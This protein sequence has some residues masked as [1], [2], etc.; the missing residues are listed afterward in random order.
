MSK[1]VFIKIIT[2]I[3]VCSMVL[4]TTAYAYGNL[5]VSS[6]KYLKPG[7]TAR[8]DKVTVNKGKTLKLHENF[9]LEVYDSITVKANGKI[10]GGGICLRSKSVSSS[11]INFYENIGG[12]YYLISGG[13][14]II[15][16]N[17]SE[18]D[19]SPNLWYDKAVGGY[20]FSNICNGGST[21]GVDTNIG[22]LNENHPDY[23]AQ[24]EEIAALKEAELS[25]ETVAGIKNTSI[26]LSSKSKPQEAKQAYNCLKWKK[27]KGYS[28]DGYRLY[29]A[30][31][32]NGKYKLIAEFK[33]D[34]EL[35]AYRDGD[36]K[37]GKTYYYKVVAFRFGNGG[38]VKT[39]ASNIVSIKAK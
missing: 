5:T 29:R 8:Y 24:Q 9:L 12:K 28:V 14:K 22:W 36:V 17:Y 38:E 19:S 13:A 23:G 4:G 1:K 3:A 32:K 39:K 18:Q 37:S 21:Y 30:T 20:C 25:D 31:K 26:T 35:N 33:A 27:S 11:G 10:T 7:N 6:D 34:T 16:K 15:V 2:A